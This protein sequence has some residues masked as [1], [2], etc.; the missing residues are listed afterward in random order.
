MK[1]YYSVF[2]YQGSFG[3]RINVGI[4]MFNQKYCISQYSNEK[5]KKVKAFK[6]EG[7]QLFDMSVKSVNLHF[8]KIKP[9][10]EQIV[11]LHRNSNN[12][13]GIDKPK[14]ISI[15]FTQENFDMLFEKIIK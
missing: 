15:E 5:L 7:F 1:L 14:E 4:V 6:K 3:E 11:K 10:K 12:I 9:T 13:F 8:N 2:F